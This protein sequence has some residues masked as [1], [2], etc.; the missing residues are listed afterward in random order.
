MRL[1]A[2]V[3]RTTCRLMLAVM[4]FAQWAVAAHACDGPLAMQAAAQEAAAMPADCDM[5]GTQDGDK[6][7]LCVDHCRSGQQ[8]SET[9]TAPVVF[10]AIPV[11]LYALP[12]ADLAVSAQS[13]PHSTVTAHAGAP[14]PP[15]HAVLH[16]VWRI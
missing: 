12:A 16:C 13:L 14:P 6:D 15:R 11:L 3:L 10:A 1:H 5:A 4:L 2:S 9:S 7:A 8:A